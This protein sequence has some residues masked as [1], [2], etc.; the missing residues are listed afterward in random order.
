MCLQI[1]LA[2]GQFARAHI[3]GPPLRQHHRSTSL[4]PK[5]LSHG[6]VVLACNTLQYSCAKACYSLFGCSTSRERLGC[7]GSHTRVSLVIIIDWPKTVVDVRSLSVLQNR[8]Q[9]SIF[10]LVDARR[11]GPFRSVCAHDTNRKASASTM[12]KAV[13]YRACNTIW[14]FKWTDYGIERGAEYY[15]TQT[16]S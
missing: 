11:K 9:V 8:G 2:N 16:G 12:V 10:S 4:Y 15:S 1:V 13:V 6:V 14:G 3:Q 5:N 7:G